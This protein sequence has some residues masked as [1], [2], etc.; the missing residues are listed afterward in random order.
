M[1]NLIVDVAKMI[2]EASFPFAAVVLAPITAW[3]V[4]VVGFVSIVRQ[5]THHL[6]TQGA[7]SQYAQFETSSWRVD[8]RRDLGLTVAV[9]IL[10]AALAILIL[11]VAV[12]VYKLLED[13]DAAQALPW[14]CCAELIAPALGPQKGPTQLGSCVGTREATAILDRAKYA[15]QARTSGQG[16]TVART[17]LFR[18]TR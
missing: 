12:S 17:H 11:V 7:G 14:L 2:D 13:A 18:K 1:G 9:N 16:M 8:M 6:P 4:V 3:L 5:K 15:W 10:G